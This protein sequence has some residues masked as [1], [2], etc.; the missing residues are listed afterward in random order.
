VENFS[1][2]NQEGFEDGNASNTSAKFTEMSH[3]SPIFQGVEFRG[4][5]LMSFI[6]R[7]QNYLFFLS[8]A[9]GK[10]AK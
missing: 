6:C 2:E 4:V 3:N 9:M 5:G 10:A 7:G 1:L 8:I